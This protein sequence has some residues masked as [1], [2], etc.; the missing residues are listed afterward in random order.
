[1]FT[2]RDSK[3]VHWDGYN[4]CKASIKK[5]NVTYVCFESFVMELSILVLYDLFYELA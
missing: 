2:T 4:G 5:E 3:V 1:M